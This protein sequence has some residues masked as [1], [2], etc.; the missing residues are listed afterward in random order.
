MEGGKASK[1]FLGAYVFI[2]QTLREAPCFSNRML[3]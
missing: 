3:R 1:S 2:L